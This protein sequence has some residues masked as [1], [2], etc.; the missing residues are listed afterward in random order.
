MKN[1]DKS[2]FFSINKRKHVSMKDEYNM[3]E[4]QEYNEKEKKF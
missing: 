1:E 2:N 3:W 4:T